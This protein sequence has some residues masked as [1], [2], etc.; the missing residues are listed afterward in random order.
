M[1]VDRLELSRMPCEQHVQRDADLARGLVLL[2]SEVGAARQEVG[3][4]IPS[5]A[6]SGSRQV[7]ARLREVG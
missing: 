4:L 6:G 2:K 5:P 1:C 3:L 7:W